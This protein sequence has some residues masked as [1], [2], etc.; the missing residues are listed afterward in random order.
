MNPENNYRNLAFAIGKLFG[1]Y[2]CAANVPQYVLIHLFTEHLGNNDK[3]FMKQFDKW[4]VEAEVKH[5]K[6]LEKKTIQA[7][8]DMIVLGNG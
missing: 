5:A 8:T 3:E 6:M 4:I 1:V 2:G 7:L